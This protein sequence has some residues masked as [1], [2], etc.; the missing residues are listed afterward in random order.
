ML[1]NVVAVRINRICIIPLTFKHLVHHSGLSDFQLV[2]CDGWQLTLAGDLDP[3][4]PV[5]HQF[6]EAKAAG[7]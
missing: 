5:D 6:G 7:S 3:S 2:G 1:R 4:D